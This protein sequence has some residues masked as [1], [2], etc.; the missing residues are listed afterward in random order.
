GG[1]PHSLDLMP[2]PAVIE[3]APVPA[4]PTAAA[5]ARGALGMLYATN[6]APVAG[7]SGDDERYYS[8]ERGYLV[9]L[10]EA[11]IHFGDGDI[12]WDEARRIALLKNRP[13]NFPL[14][15]EDVREFGILPASVSVFTPRE[16]AAGVDETAAADFAT[17]I[18]QRLARS[19]VKD[20]FVYVHGYKVN[21]ENPL[22]VA[23]EMWHFLGQDGAFVAF[24]WPSTPARLAYMKDIETARV[25]AWG[26]RRF[27]DYLA[28]ST[29]A[30]RIHV[31][32]YSAGT[33]VVLTALYELALLHQ[34]EE[35]AAIAAQ[36]RLGNV[37]L[38]GSDVDT[39]TFA[40][41]V[42]DGLLDVQERLTLYT[43]PADKALALS[44]KLFAH[45]RLGQVLP[46]ALDARMREFVAASSRLALVD[47]AEADNFDSGNG[48]AY[49][50]NSPWVSADILFTLRHGLP[51][52]ARGLEQRD[53][54]PVWRF[55][56]DYLAR[57]DRALAAATGGPAPSAETLE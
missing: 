5:D 42:I 27:L 44:H 6:R 9:R 22:L 28:T 19:A 45:R 33:R 41:Y 48:H 36:T 30:R 43:S 17:A 2:A 50:R 3:A 29:S 13:G 54:S 20:V 25:A 4:V 47:V 57:F 10:G 12:S 51:P 40:S 1:V 7:V 32:G 38:V 23:A 15:V 37:I 11:D 16:V 53:D 52:Q 24:S 55:P 56:A 35:P 26:L 39:G 49:F 34:G 14:R 31:V 8:G 21:F 18:D 46:G